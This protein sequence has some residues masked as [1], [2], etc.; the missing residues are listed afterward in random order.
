MTAAPAARHPVDPE[1]L[2]RAAA[3]VR[4][5]AAG[6]QPPSFGHVPN[7]D[8]ALFLCAIDHR[9]GYRGRY[10]VGGRGPFSGSAL[11]WELACA[12]ER[13]QPDA[14]SAGRQSG[15]DLALGADV[16]E[17]SD[18]MTIGG[19]R[20]ARAAE[21]GADRGAGRVGLRGGSSYW[22]PVTGQDRSETEAT[23]GFRTS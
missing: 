1:L 10:L 20:A 13:R 7:P 16:D 2:H 21:C 19:D 23:A 11:L 5:L 3:R 9:T 14:L 12:K 17:Q 22:R 18:M 6:Y 4:E 15:H 8:A